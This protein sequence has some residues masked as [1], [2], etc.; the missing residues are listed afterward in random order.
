MKYEGGNKLKDISTWEDRSKNSAK[1]LGY[2]VIK[3]FTCTTTIQG[4][5][6]GK[7]YISEDIF[8][9]ILWYGTLRSVRKEAKIRKQKA[10]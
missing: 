8:K 10:A 4:F 3:G 6:Y 5:S 9:L 1:P 7:S 2:G